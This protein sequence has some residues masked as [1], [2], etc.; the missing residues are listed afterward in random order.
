[1][2][3]GTCGSFGFGFG[4]SAKQNISNNTDSVSVRIVIC[5]NKEDGADGVGITSHTQQRTNPYRMMM[6]TTPAKLQVSH[7]IFA[8]SVGSMP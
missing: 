8:V 2:K 3:S 6:T 7:E 4:A 1:V 5:V